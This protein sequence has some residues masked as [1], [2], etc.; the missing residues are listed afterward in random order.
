MEN[1][2]TNSHDLRAANALMLTRAALFAAWSVIERQGGAFADALPTAKRQY[3]E[4]MNL[5]A[6]DDQEPESDPFTDDA[7][8]S[9]QSPRFPILGESS[10]PFARRPEF[11]VGWKFGFEPFQFVIRQ[12]RE[13][14]PQLLARG[15]APPGRDAFGGFDPRP[16][17]AHCF[18]PPSLAVPR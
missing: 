4:T 9:E 1:T 2:L 10:I 16:N 5:M 7:A 11:G 17:R 8:D 6:E 14:L 15:H 12:R 13:P 3:Q 18:L